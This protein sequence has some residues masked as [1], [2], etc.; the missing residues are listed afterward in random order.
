MEFA[1]AERSRS[2]E[3]GRLPRQLVETFAQKVRI[4]EVRVVEEHYV[5]A[6]PHL[7]FDRRM[8]PIRTPPVTMSP[9]RLR[10]RR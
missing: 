1:P 2:G 9:R 4:I 8:Q 7:E 5:D 10:P 6:A 3:S